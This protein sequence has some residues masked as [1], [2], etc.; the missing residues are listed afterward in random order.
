[1]GRGLARH[2]PERH[3]QL[4]THACEELSRRPLEIG[5]FSWVEAAYAA[6]TIEPLCESTHRALAK[7]FLAE[8]VATRARQQF[9]LCQRMLADETG[10][11]PSEQFV[12]LVTT[13]APLPPQPSTK[14]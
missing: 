13:A 8:G 2:R 9:Q 3:P 14:D 10:Y 11:A 1:L 4:R 7:A 5:C 6:I 12:S